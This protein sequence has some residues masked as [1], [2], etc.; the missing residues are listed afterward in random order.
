[1]KKFGTSKG[2]ELIIQLLQQSGIQF[3]REKTFSD[4]GKGLLR[5]DFFVPSMN[6]C[7]ECDG[8]QHFHQVKRFQET[9]QDFLKAQEHD[10]RKNSYCLANDIRL[11]RIPYWELS[12][13]KTAQDIFQAKFLV[14]SKW[15]N[16][17][18]FTKKFQSEE[19]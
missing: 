6:T 15:H 16:D 3:M 11:Y 8:E 2:E 1:M 10:R 9:R 13:L 17:N 4:L 18:L 14:Q 19:K 5:Y 12:N 7:V